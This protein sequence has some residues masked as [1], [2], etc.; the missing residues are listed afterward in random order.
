MARIGIQYTDVKHTA[1]Q[2]L[3]QGVAPSV[4]KIRDKLGTGSNTTIAEHLNT[5]R[6]EYANKEIHH[7]P[8]NLPPEL[9]SATE[10]L[11]QAAM[12]QATH[13]LTAIKKELTEQQAKLNQE[14]LIQDQKIIVL[15]ASEANAQQIIES[16]NT[17]IQTQKT[18]LA[19][20]QERFCGQ[21]AEL[22]AVKNQH[23]IR[24]KQ[25]Y[26]EK[27]DVMEQVEKYQ[28]ET[29]QL[30][31]QLHAQSEKHQQAMA[32]ERERQE[33]SE[34]R[35]LQLIDQARTESNR[36]RKA[37][38]TLN[39][40]QHK[41]IEELKDRVAELRNKQSN[42]DLTCKKAEK[43]NKELNHQLKKVQEQYQTALLKISTLKSK[44][45]STKK[46]IVKNSTLDQWYQG[47]LKS[48]GYIC[49][50]SRPDL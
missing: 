4:Q 10:V 31:Q 49:P 34:N 48:N 17:Q 39:T 36:L 11:W 44:Q 26:D 46:K 47:L 30:Q 43:L 9:I 38:E 45:E 6:E 12:E 18:E 15:Q 7:L 3:S 42:S 37:N 8:A 24:L 22:T 41:H 27:H 25:A 19:V 23:E 21:S 33:Q 13:Q 50:G 32:H 2:L 16:K 5:W 14:K 28:A 29:Q 35:W 40:K 20:M 1:V